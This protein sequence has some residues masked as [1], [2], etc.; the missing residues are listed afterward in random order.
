MNKGFFKLDPSHPGVQARLARAGMLHASKIGEVLLF[1]EV[2]AALVER[3][4][5]ETNTFHFPRGEATI[6]LEDV[7]L[8]LGLRCTGEV[9]IWHTMD[10][11]VMD[12]CAQ[13][14][15][16]VPPPVRRS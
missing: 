7:A 13:Y 5:P 2:T 11:T 9:V 12:M 10:N 15:P 16:E 8:L 1:N 6:T 3:W 4:R 14:L